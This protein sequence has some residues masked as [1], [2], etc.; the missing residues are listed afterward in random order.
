MHLPRYWAKE[1]RTAISPARK[2]FAL[3]TWGWSDID[4]ADAR[5][6]ALRRLAELAR[7]VENGVGL[8]HYGQYGDGTRPLREPLVMAVPGS[9][10]LVSRNAYGALVLNTPN[11]FFA[12]IDLPEPESGG[13]LGS[14]FGKKP[15]DP[16]DT[17][18]NRLK[19]W[20]ARQP[21]WSMRV[22]RTRA[23]LRLLATHAEFDPVSSETRQLLSSLGSDPLYTVLC[24]QQACF[25]ARLTPKPWR[26]GLRAPA[27]RYPFESSSHAS[28]FQG[29]LGRYEAAAPRFAVCRLLVELGAA[30]QAPE[31]AVVAAFHDRYTCPPG[32]LPL[33]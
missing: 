5:Q 29:W 17:A 26:I 24:R 4:P 1:T 7:K 9:Q 13:L 15:T 11:V 23:G 19:D 12:D 22:Y 6:S 32:N 33:A 2:A 14:L 20:I 8:G 31:A 27:W 28:A 21:G 30:R 18:L 3:S 10:A 25:R 16:V